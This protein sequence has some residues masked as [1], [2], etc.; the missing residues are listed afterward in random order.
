MLT[1]NLIIFYVESPEKSALF[2]SGLFDH[3]PEAVYPTYAAFKFENGLNFGLW[4]VNA[5]DFVSGGIG[6]RSEISFMVADPDIVQEIYDRWKNA[7]VTIEQ[8]LHE[9]VFRLKP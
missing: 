2:Y 6:H 9:A 1:P 3:T 8:P 4:S 7:G 5:N